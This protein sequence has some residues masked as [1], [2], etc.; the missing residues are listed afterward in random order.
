MNNENN[1]EGLNSISLGNIDN[2]NSVPPVVPPTPDTLQP[3]GDIPN[4]VPTPVESVPEVAPVSP[5]TEQPSI[6]TP[7]VDNIPMGGA[8]PDVPAVPS[9]PVNDVPPVEPVTPVAPVNYDVPETINNFN[10]TPFLNEIG[11]VPP[12]PNVP[13]NNNLGDINN[14][15]NIPKKKGGMNK[16]LF[17]L[18]I[19]LALTA[20]G[21]GVYIFLNLNNQSKK[22]SVAV[23]NVQI[24]LGGEVSNKL[25]DYAT[26]TN[27]SSSVCTLDTTKITDTSVLDATYDFTIT[28]NG[29]TYNGKAKIVDSVN[30]EVVSDTVTIS[31]NEEVNA[32]D[33]ISECKDASNC[34]YKFK[35]E[36]QVRN[37][38]KKAGTYDDIII[39][40]SDAANNTI[41]VKVTLIVEE[42][43]SLFISCSKNGSEEITK[44]VLDNET[45]QFNGQVLREISFKLSEE[46][47][48]KFKTENNNKVTVTYE[49]I[50]GTA[51]YDDDN[52]V[53]TISK[54]LSTTEIE[55]EFGKDLPK[56]FSGLRKQIN[57][58]GYSCSLES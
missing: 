48:F 12:I 54:E 38:I 27:I 18:I 13:V 58:M 11:T 5:V 2:L 36:S 39:L 32:E 24:E 30:P 3:N 41:E 46:D 1:N 51:I 14:N 45:N 4:V 20:V 37:Y 8:I 6:P 52:Y 56:T 47:Y 53:L 25:E 9:V 19:T 15:N 35:D 55:N 7:Q 21:V 16:I 17:V 49:G 26:F 29:L 33:F 40:V 34:T 10:A 44:F 28:C 43:A 42:G 23:K 50:T 31:V 57:S 22:V